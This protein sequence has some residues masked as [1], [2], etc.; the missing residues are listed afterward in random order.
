MFETKDQ[1]QIVFL[2]AMKNQGE[3][4]LNDYHSTPEGVVFSFGPKDNCESSIS[5]YFSLKT[6]PIQPK[7]LL[8]GLDEFKNLLRLA[9]GNYGNS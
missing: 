5:D 7:M 4:T 6:K 9:K 1:R 2:L 3:I 8:D